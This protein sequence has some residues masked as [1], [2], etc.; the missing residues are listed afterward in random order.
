MTTPDGGFSPTERTIP[1]AANTGA[2]GPLGL[3]LNADRVI[4]RKQVVS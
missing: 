2:V 4:P 3:E 1:T